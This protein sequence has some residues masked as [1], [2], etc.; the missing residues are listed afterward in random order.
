MSKSQD[1]EI[2]RHDGLKIRWSQDLEGFRH[3]RT[4]QNSQHEPY[5]NNIE[6]VSAKNR[7]GWLKL[8]L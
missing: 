3:R 1:G 4:L 2:G 5:M 7:L 6:K 8:F